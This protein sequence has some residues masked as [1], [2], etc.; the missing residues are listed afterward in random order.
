MLKM[1]TLVPAMMMMWCPY[2]SC[3]YDSQRIASGLQAKFK[4]TSGFALLGFI[5]F[6]FLVTFFLTNRAI[7]TCM[8]TSRFVYS[9]CPTATLRDLPSVCRLHT[10]LDA[11]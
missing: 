10:S 9:I 3:R 2:A 4:T 5:A 1:H 8:Q 7:C 11:L 6:A